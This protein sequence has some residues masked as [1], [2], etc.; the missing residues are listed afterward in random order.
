MGMVPG[1]WT[2]FNLM[3]YKHRWETYSVNAVFNY[4]DSTG[5]TL[6]HAVV[7]A[8]LFENMY[9]SAM[10]HDRTVLVQNQ[11][12]FK[13]DP[14]TNGDQYMGL[15]YANSSLYVFSRGWHSLARVAVYALTTIPITST[16]TTIPNRIYTTVNATAAVQSCGGMG[17]YQSFNLGKDLVF[18]CWNAHEK[19]AYFFYYD[20]ISISELGCSNYTDIVEIGSM[21]LVGT[22]TSFEI[23]MIPNTANSS[24]NSMRLT[25]DGTPRRNITRTSGALVTIP[26]KFTMIPPSPTPTSKSESSSGGGIGAGAIIGTLVAA[27]IALVG[28]MMLAR[29][30]NS[31]Q[32]AESALA[33]TR[34]RLHTTAAS[35]ITTILAA[36]TVRAPEPSPS[37]TRISFYFFARYPKPSLAP[38][39]S[40]TLAAT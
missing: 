32:N 1:T 9:L 36:A 22:S 8:S 37:S 24:I 19:Q 10:N 5:N 39:P 12:Y 35:S 2:A 25:N 15:G 16:S 26:E 34:I 13:V 6:M 33:L 23:F 31:A 14:D 40:S 20:G 3:G 27:L 17:Y 29:K 4:K 21:V 28:L 38:N 30:R 11:Q 18:N 7:N